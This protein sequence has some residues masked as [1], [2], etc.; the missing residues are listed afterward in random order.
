MASSSS[1]PAEDFTWKSGSSNILVVVRC[2]PLSSSERARRE[3]EVVRIEDGKTI[4]I[5]D[6]GHQATNLMR[7]KRLK[8]R[9][10]AFDHAFAQ[11]QPTS[12]VYAL[13]TRF[14]VAGVMEGYNATVFAYGATG[15][16]KTFTMLG[17]A[18]SPGLMPS[19]LKDLWSG[20]A[21][22]SSSRVYTVTISYVE[23]YNENIRDLLADSDEYLDLR[24]DPIKVRGARAPDSRQ[25]PAPNPPLPLPARRAPA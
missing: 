11:A 4:E 7:Q 23:I 15:S 5:R 1:P 14:L 8:A 19:T 10:Y 25:P 24:E 22:Y 12:A 9:A 18:A 6:P 2:R 3:E 20:M 16:G 17:N 13:T 21:Q